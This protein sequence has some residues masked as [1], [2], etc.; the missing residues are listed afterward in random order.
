MSNRIQRPGGDA[1]RSGESSREPV[2]PQTRLP[3]A[4]A[5][6]KQANALRQAQGAGFERGGPLGASRRVKIDL[7]DYGRATNPLDPNDVNPEV[8]VQSR[9]AEVT[10]H[11]TLQASRFAALG[12]QVRGGR[13]L[14][15]ALIDGAFVPS[16]TDVAKLEVLAQ[17]ARR[18]NK[19]RG[20]EQDASP[21]TDDAVDESSMDE[22]LVAQTA[23][24]GEAEVDAA[25]LLEALRRAGMQEL[26][27]ENASLGKM[28]LAVG[29][30]VAGQGTGVEV[31]AGDVDASSLADEVST[32][33]RR[34]KEAV[35]EFE[36]MHAGISRQVGAYQTFVFKR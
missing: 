4:V 22:E 26:T 24:E 36:R 7:G 5:R 3:D 31:V 27:A 21:V 13:G 12:E 11:L 34:G 19:K 1:P 30:V 29:L 16:E 32:V 28:L 8:W 35:S 6:A 20:V 18:K 9:L 10:R 33:L 23:A 15:Q 2:G 25:A 14:G 17:R